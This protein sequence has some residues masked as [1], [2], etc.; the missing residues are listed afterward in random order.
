VTESREFPAFLVSTAEYQALT[1]LAGG[2][3]ALLPRL[4]EPEQSGLRLLVDEYVKVAQ[5]GES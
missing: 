2:V 4:P 5:D 1:R 3:M